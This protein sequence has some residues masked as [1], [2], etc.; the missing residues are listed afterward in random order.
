M[1]HPTA[2]ASAHGHHVIPK[3]ILLRVFL[4]LVGLTVLTVAAAMVDL[5]AL[6]VPLAL[7]IAAVKATLVVSI[8]MALKY[9][10]PV[11]T[12]VFSVGSI[13]VVV[14]LSFTLF[15]TAFRGDLGNVSRETIKDM[16]LREQQ[17]REERPQLFGQQ[18]A[19]AAADTTVAP[20]DS[21]AA[22]PEAGAARN[23]AAQAP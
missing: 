11:N 19:A 15:D 18:S 13:F 14:F 7:A 12:L 22:A 8:F 4:T 9:D 5:G 21:A 20:A 2:E 3:K 1:A 23:S 6:N 17:L 16:E 10:A